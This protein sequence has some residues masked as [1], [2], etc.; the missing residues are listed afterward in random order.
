MTGTSNGL[1]L[2][3]KTA[4][5]DD[6][7]PARILTV[8][9]IRLYRSS[10]MLLST[11]PRQY[12]EV[13][14]IVFFPAKVDSDFRIQIIKES[15]LYPVD[16]VTLNAATQLQASLG[17][18]RERFNKAVSA[19]QILA[20]YAKFHNLP[21]DK[22]KGRLN[23]KLN[24]W[25]LEICKYPDHILES[26][27][28]QLVSKEQAGEDIKLAAPEWEW[29]APLPSNTMP[30]WPE[31]RG[32]PS[33]SV[34]S[35]HQAVH[36]EGIRTGDPT[37]AVARANRIGWVDQRIRGAELRNS[38]YQVVQQKVAA[39]GSRLKATINSGDSRNLPGLVNLGIVPKPV[40]PGLPGVPRAGWYHLAGPPTQNPY[41]PS[42]ML[43]LEPQRTTDQRFQQIQLSAS[44]DSTPAIGS[45]G[46]GDK[47]IHPSVQFHPLPT[48][49]RPRVPSTTP[50]AFAHGAQTIVGASTTPGVLR[51]SA[52]GN[53]QSRI[54]VDVDQLEMDWKALLVR[55]SVCKTVA[56]RLHQ[57]FLQRKCKVRDLRVALGNISLTTQQIDLTRNTLSDAIVEAVVSRDLQRACKIAR[58]AGLGF[59]RPEL[60]RISKEAYAIGDDVHASSLA[61]MVRNSC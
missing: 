18:Q 6:F 57:D 47:R 56:Q 8:E 24:K 46:L 48:A 13:A 34:V 27:W 23:A 1:V 35:Q 50:V 14:I 44:G 26:D 55:E 37:G 4:G 25:H 17:L 41:N 10:G 61:D 7:W 11:F 22:P 59:A 54:S 42:G 33:A 12:E 28:A 19:V 32:L 9:E 40:P 38:G 2:A 15:Q 39:A 36:P 5:T 53:Q 60:D 29:L 51:S 52:A 16:S 45:A 30:G 43:S 20:R 31:E 3:A 58:I 49:K 21:R